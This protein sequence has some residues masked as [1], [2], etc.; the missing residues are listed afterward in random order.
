MGEDMA[1]DELEESLPRLISKYF[2]HGLLF[3]LLAIAFMIVGIVF[4]VFLVALGLGGILLI[5]AMLVIFPL[6]IG[7][8]NSVITEYLWF[9]VKMSW[10]GTWGMA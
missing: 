7:A 4:L 3:S 1:E 6:L 5:I 8:A 2:V 9:P 10:T